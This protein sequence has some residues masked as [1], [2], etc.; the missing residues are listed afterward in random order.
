MIGDA[1]AEEHGVTYTDTKQVVCFVEAASG[2]SFTL[3]VQALNV[4]LAPRLHAKVYI[5][6][7]ERASK[8][9][10]PRNASPLQLHTVELEGTYEEGGQNRGDGSRIGYLRKWRFKDLVTSGGCFFPISLLHW[11]PFP[12]GRI[13]RARQ[14]RPRAIADGL[15]LKTDEGDAVTAE[16]LSKIGTIEVVVWRWRPMTLAEQR[17][18]D[19]PS[20]HRHEH[21]RHHHRHHHHDRERHAGPL[22]ETINEKSVKGSAIS[23]VV[24]IGDRSLS[25]C[26]KSVPG[27]SLD[28]ESAPYARFIF[29]YASRARLECLSVLPTATSAA[30]TWENMS[31]EELLQEL[32]RKNAVRLQGD[33]L[34]RVDLN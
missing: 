19:R 21:H 9:S 20:E 10:K 28:A 27:I 30:P 5:D 18:S 3:S 13:C 32:R 11:F 2:K 4:L 33:T 6:G 25:N 31:R 29:R 16:A 7:I 17:G 24:A 14:R 12:S 23:H 34:R 1:V 26:I 15:R 22:P 8:L